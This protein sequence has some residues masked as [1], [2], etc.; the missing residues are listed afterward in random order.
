MK[1]PDIDK[2]RR[3]ALAAG[4]ILI[5]YFVAG[6]EPSP[7]VIF[8]V[9]GISFQIMSP[10]YIPIGFILVSLYGGIRFLFYGIL[11]NKSPSNIRKSMTLNPTIDNPD[12]Y[13]IKIEPEQK[14]KVLSEL[15]YAFPYINRLGGVTYKEGI[16]ESH[17]FGYIYFSVNWK[18]RI[19][20]TIHDA[21][22]TSPVWV[23]AFALLF[24][25]YKWFAV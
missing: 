15:S 10:E 6:V 11:I 7:P 23:N 18:T 21:D 22:Y 12:M 20:A 24:S 17:N 19:L 25:A 14:S 13:M 3:F 8:S 1:Q 5:T 16:S 4:L 2:L 9:L